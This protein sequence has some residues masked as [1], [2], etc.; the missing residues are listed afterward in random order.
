MHADYDILII[1]GGIKGCGIARDAAGRGFRVLLAEMNDLASGTSSASTK[2]IHGGLRYLEHYEFRLVRESLIERERLWK[3]APHIIWP[4]RF[5][6]PYHKGLRPVWMLRLGLFLYDHIG[7]RRALPAT[8]RLDLRRDPAGQPLR[9]G[10]DTAFEYS[11]GWVQDA[12]LVVLNAMDARHHGAEILTRTRVSRLSRNG[13]LFRAELEGCGGGRREVTARLVVNATGPWVD[14]VLERVAGLNSA[15][16]VRLVKGSHIVVPRM[17][18]HDRAYIFQNR[19]G[20]IVFAI[21]Y[22]RD[23][24]LIGTTDRD[25]RGDPGQVAIAE[26]EVLYLC[27]AASEYFHAPV[28]PEQV[29]W[30]YSGVRPLYKDSASKAQEATRDYVVKMDARPDEGVRIDIFG[31]KSRPIGASPSRSS[32]RSKPSSASV[33]ARGPPVDPCQ[34]ETF[35]CMAS[36]IWWPSY[37]RPHPAS[38][39]PPRVALPATTARKRRI[40]SARTASERS[41]A[42]IFPPAKPAISCST[43]GLGL[44]RIFSGGGRSLGWSSPPRRREGSRPLWNGSDRRHSMAPYI[45]AIDQG[46]TSTRT[47]VFDGRYH[48][49]GRAQTEFRQSFPNSGWVEHDAEEIWETVV[50]TVRAALADAG[51]SA[52][53]VGALGITNQRETVVVWDR[54]TGRPIHPTVVWQDRRTA[55]FCARLIDDGAEAE[56]TERTGLLIDPYFSATKLRWILD[57]VE[58]HASGRKQG[59][60]PL[61]RLTAGSSGN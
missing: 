54:A 56:V 31:G 38:R 53:N 10:F 42:P 46:T 26:E 4:L 51:V 59:V 57:H 16:N 2:L 55:D 43:N 29:V 61:A 15:R 34:A 9:P 44:R 20:R 27:K 45:V 22:E 8:R 49:V 24:T 6:L 37:P 33:A 40:C 41:S 14:Q 25:Y 47:Y 18:E 23:F 21:P 60:S 58:A 12:R 28:A 35:R 17:F 3:I 7:G 13:G 52:N 11:D 30:S 50:A 1:G 39:R 36:R 48:I 32:I 19:D 5:V